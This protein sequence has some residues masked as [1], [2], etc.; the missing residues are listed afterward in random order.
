MVRYALYSTIDL[1]R[2]QKTETP[3]WKSDELY[4]FYGIS[5]RY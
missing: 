4:D 2:R 1:T 5:R 3:K